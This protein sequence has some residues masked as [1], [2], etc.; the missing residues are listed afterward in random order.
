MLPPDAVVLLLGTAAAAEAAAAAVV[1]V[2]AATAAATAAA[3]AAAALRVPERP[4]LGRGACACC[5]PP[6]PSRIPCSLEPIPESS[7]AVA[8]SPLPD[9]AGTTAFAAPATPATSTTLTT[10]AASA[11]AAPAASPHPRWAARFC[12]A[13]AV[14]ECGVRQR[15]HTQPHST[16]RRCRLGFIFERSSRSPRLGSRAGATTSSGGMARLPR[17]SSS[18]TPRRW[19]SPTQALGWSSSTPRRE[20]KAPQMVRGSLAT[21]KNVQQP[22]PVCHQ[23]GAKTTPAHGARFLRRS[24]AA[25]RASHGVL[26]SIDTC[27]ITAVEEPVGARLG[28]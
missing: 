8:D 14:Q 17:A 11:P 22:H 5:S 27:E 2:A 21:R 24:L 3:A 9:T 7:R 4:R 28:A 23:N 19:V 10:S 16:P 1:V 26:K 25:K 20:A 18:S 15:I 13:R 12:A 6:A